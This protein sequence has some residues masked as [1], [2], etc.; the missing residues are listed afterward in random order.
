MLDQVY[1]ATGK[2]LETHVNCVASKLG[3]GP[4]VITGKIKSH[5]GDGAHR[6]QQLELR[7][8]TV[9]PKLEK[10]CLKLMTYSLLCVYC[11]EILYIATD[12]IAQ[13]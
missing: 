6:M 5:F 4:H 11:V 13:H 2:V 10:Q 8:T 12:I 1:T 7:Q 3:L 9:P